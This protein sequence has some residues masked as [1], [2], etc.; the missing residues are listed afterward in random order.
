M[1]EQ[2]N[3]KDKNFAEDQDKKE[4]S[5]HQ[6]YL[7]VI[8]LYVYY[9]YYKWLPLFRF[10]FIFFKFSKTWSSYT[11]TDLVRIWNIL[12]SKKNSNS[13]KPRETRLGWIKK[14][15]LYSDLRPET[16]LLHP[17]LLIV[18]WSSQVSDSSGISKM[19]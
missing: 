4:V 18:L 15:L 12:V 17:S 6:D 2:N 5:H 7:K 16:K 10:M 3:I 8:K 9:G 14:E 13:P 1:D 11:R 19:K